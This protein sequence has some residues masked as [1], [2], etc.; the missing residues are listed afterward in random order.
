MPGS[1]CEIKTTAKFDDKLSRVSDKMIHM[2][3]ELFILGSQVPR[4]EKE[5]PKCSLQI[6]S[7]TISLYLS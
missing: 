6:Y 1:D 5:L 3:V 2:R 7:P 4:G